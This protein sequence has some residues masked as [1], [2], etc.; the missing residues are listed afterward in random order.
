MFVDGVSKK[1]SG[2]WFSNGLLE[3]AMPTHQQ[4]D[5]LFV[6]LTINPSSFERSRF[7]ERYYRFIIPETFT[8]VTDIEY[9]QKTEPAH[10]LVMYRELTDSEPNSYLFAIK[11]TNE[12]LNTGNNDVVT[13]T[14]IASVYRGFDVK[15]LIND[16]QSTEQ[17]YESLL[18]NTTR[19]QCQALMFTYKYQGT[20]THNSLTLRESQDDLQ[21][22]D[23]IIPNKGAITPY[24]YTANNAIAGRTLL[25]LAPSSFGGEDDPP[26]SGTGVGVVYPETSFRKPLILT[27]YE[28]NQDNELVEVDDFVQCIAASVKFNSLGACIGGTLNLASNQTR[29]GL[30]LKPYSRIFDLSL[31]QIATI[32]GFVTEIGTEVWYR[33]LLGSFPKIHPGKGFYQLPVLGLYQLVKNGFTYG[34]TNPIKPPFITE[35]GNYN[36]GIGTDYTAGTVDDYETWDKYF[37]KIYKGVTQAE[38][39]VGYDSR[40]VRGRPQDASPLV[41]DAR[42]Y[43]AT[44]AESSE[45]EYI[46][47]YF[48]KPDDET[49]PVVYADERTD[50]PS[51][52][53]ERGIQAELNGSG[54][55]IIPEGFT[56]PVAQEQSFEFSYPGILIPPVLVTNLPN[57]KQ[58]YVSQANV[59]LELNG[60]RVETKVRTENLILRRK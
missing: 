31:I 4:G 15:R 19:Q 1:R 2:L 37:K 16:K 8:Y 9:G 12:L 18:V 7:G 25:A 36:D 34:Q 48:V 60:T 32:N 28:L 6:A 54:L 27:S 26:T 46:T 11:Q 45:N 35:K 22:E 43:N 5:V 47:A 17:L 21:L 50:L 24:D 13:L 14:G 33:C 52:I 42:Q 30:Q 39:G 59:R 10:A 57:G 20:L 38:W 58:Q 49:Q 53:P 41:I 23:G 44:P 56:L 3:L 55:P 29:R 40:F 51:I